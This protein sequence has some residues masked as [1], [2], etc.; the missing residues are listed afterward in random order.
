MS[1][2]KVLHLP[3]HHSPAAAP[4]VTCMDYISG[5]D[6]PD[7]WH[8]ALPGQPLSSLVALPAVH[9]MVPV[10]TGQHHSPRLLHTLL[11]HC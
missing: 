4:T 9:C 1:A 6:C 3:L 8:A 5:H 2:I 7:S 10:V 11:E